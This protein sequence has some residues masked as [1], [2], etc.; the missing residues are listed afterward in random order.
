LSAGHIQVAGA[1]VALP[2]DGHTWQQ[3]RR[4]IAIEL[5]R[6]LN[7]TPEQT[8]QIQAIQTIKTRFPNAVKQ[9]RAGVA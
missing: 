6:R 3:V 8:Q 9:C 1:P 5:N 2:Q 4:L 7:L